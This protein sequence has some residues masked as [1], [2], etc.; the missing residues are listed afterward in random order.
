MLSDK[1]SVT[2]I[3]LLEAWTAWRVSILPIVSVLGALQFN[4]FNII[5]L[6]MHVR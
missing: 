6:D 2:Q 1:V 4:L 5:R 3:P